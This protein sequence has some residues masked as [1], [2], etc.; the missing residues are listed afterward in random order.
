MYC[1]AP[2]N[3]FSSFVFSG[4][5]SFYI[6]STFS[7]FGFIPSP[8]VSCPGHFVLFMKNSDC[9]ILIRYPAFFSLFSTS[10]IFFSC[11]FLSPRNT[12][13]ITSNHAGV[14][15]FIV[16]SMFSWNFVRISASQSIYTLSE[17]VVPADF[18]SGCYKNA[19]SDR[20]I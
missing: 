5:F 12:S 4:G 18:S 13:I 7:S 10:K 20:F 11:S 6:A 15:Y 14:Q 19:L 8:S 9:F 3:D 17:Y 16:R 2:R 1:I